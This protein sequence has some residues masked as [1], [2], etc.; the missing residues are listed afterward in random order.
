MRLRSL[1]LFLTAVVFIPF[2]V[3]AASAVR[4]GN[5]V[6]DGGTLVRRLENDINTLNYILQTTQYERWVL[7]CLY[8][9]LID[10]DANLQPV[11]GTAARWE[12]S[13]DHLIYTLHLDRRSTFSDG[14]PVLASDVVFTH[15]SCR[16]FKTTRRYGPFP[17]AILPNAVLKSPFA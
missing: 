14:T 9:P 16:L 7:S 4:P 5:K 6:R 15:G 10:L 2:C 11:P 17:T 8:D 13:P 3:L 12:V 1:G